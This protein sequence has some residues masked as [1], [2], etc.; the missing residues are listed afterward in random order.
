MLVL[1]ML[2]ILKTVLL[3]GEWQSKHLLSHF[4][5]YFSSVYYTLN[6]FH[7]NLLSNGINHNIPFFR[8]V[9]KYLVHT[10]ESSYV[11]QT[12]S[13]ET[14]WPRHA[15]LFWETHQPP[16]SIK[17]EQMYHKNSAKIDTKSFFF[18]SQG[19]GEQPKVIVHVN[20]KHRGRKRDEVRWS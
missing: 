14:H 12:M 15:L 4:S 5:K 13:Y 8:F 1:K 3:C 6:S 11:E 19:Y 16:A 17:H 20:T 7:S 10:T 18:Y 9:I 2:P